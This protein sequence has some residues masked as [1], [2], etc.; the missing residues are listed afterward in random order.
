MKVG[1]V[2]A[3]GSGKTS[4]VNLLPRL[5]P[6]QR[7]RILVDGVPIERLERA[8][9]R[10]QLGYV[11][12]DVVVFAGTV[13]A[14]LNAALPRVLVDDARVVAACR[15]TGLAEVLAKLPGGLDHH[16]IEGGENLSMGERQLVAFTRMLLRDPAILILDE[17]TANIDEHCEQLIQHAISEVMEGRTSFVIAHRLST[18]I[19]CDIILVF[20]GGRLVEQGRHQELLAKGGVYAELAGK[21]LAV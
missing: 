11:S 14:N 4:T 20:A 12:Q 7:G 1:L 2:G 19:Q 10:R 9:L 3:T 6:Y 18:I 8:G 5:Y 17:A 21:Q 15:Q 16:I 13:R